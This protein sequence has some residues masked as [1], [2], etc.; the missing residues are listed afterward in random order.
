MPTILI[1]GA[2]RGLGLEMA[3][4]Y[5]ADGWR[6]LGCA[7]SPERAAELNALA[8]ESSGRVSVHRLDVADHAQV[9]ALAAELHGQPID[10]LV[11][12]SGTMGRESF[13]DKGMAIQ[14]FGET[15]YDDWAQVMRVNV[16]GPMKMA[17][18]FVTQVAASEQ[19]KLVTLT[20]MV[21]SMTQN[22]SGGLY[23]YRSS[24][25]A[26]NMV[27]KSMSLDLK[28]HG[29]IALPL[30][31]GWART[32]IGGP[33][34]ELDAATSVTGMRKVIAGLTPA[35]AG[36]FLQWDGRELPW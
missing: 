36:H 2:N 23:A 18:A 3:R 35:Q 6:V 19:K 20:S 24:K 27:M 29:I 8:A 5:A 30:H 31:P 32:E 14:R 11:N 9:E 25:A 34:A 17:E 1:T 26:A 4:Q 13:A 16:F 10:V 33:R 28:R 22:T 15:D 12:S 7:R 21:G